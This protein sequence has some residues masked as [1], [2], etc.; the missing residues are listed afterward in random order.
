M[1]RKI[2]QTIILLSFYKEKSTDS[3]SRSAMFMLKYSC[4]LPRRVCS[5]AGYFFV[6][7]PFSWHAVMVPMSHLTFQW[8]ISRDNKMK[9]C[10]SNSRFSCGYISMWASQT[11]WVKKYITRIAP[12]SACG[13]SK[14]S[15]LYIKAPCA[16]F[17]LY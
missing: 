13:H 14:K 1:K 4:C 8:K 2:E 12:C 11:L 3:V 7:F 10:R 9:G 17:L 15:I 16:F 5:T 6:H